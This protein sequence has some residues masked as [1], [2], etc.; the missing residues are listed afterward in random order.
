MPV[1]N[2]VI[3]EFQ[4]IADKMHA[5]H[6]AES[7]KSREERQ[8]DQKKHNDEVAA[9]LE[10]HKA[11]VK[12]DLET[13]RTEQARLIKERTSR[14]PTGLIGAP[15]GDMR[16]LGQR[17]A[18]ME[19]YKAWAANDHRTKAPLQLGLK[20]RIRQPIE[21]KVAGTIVETGFPMVP[22]RVGYFAP[23]TLPLVMRDLLTVVTLTSGNSIDYVVETWNYAANYQV[24]EGDPK[25]QGDVTYL[26]KT[27]SVR[28]IA[29]YVKASRQMMA[30]APYF[31]ATVDSQLLYGLAKKEDHEILLGDN[32]AGHL[33]GII[34][35]ATAL[36][37]DI[38][39][40]ILNSFDQVLAAVAY[41]ASI[42]YSPTAI[43]LNPIDWANMQIAK[44][45]Q[46]IYILGGPP[47]GMAARTLWGLPVVMTSE[48]ALGTFLVG[49][50]PPNATL[51]DRESPSVDIAYENEDDFIKNLVTIRAEERIA[52]AVFRPQAFVTSTLVPP[53]VP[54][55][56][57]APAPK[58]KR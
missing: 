19:Q 13:L 18:E 52:L 1:D 36:P 3:G 11:E 38:L 51:F 49:A 57:A 43:V 30:D 9:L 17:F 50:F 7:V 16:S 23:P 45:S 4:K 25:A 8:A 27:A 31:A 55:A 58:E 41:L 48:M 47:S 21:V 56:A 15:D 5:D 24:L 37:A 29:W 33:H 26:E 46:G 39:T 12:T 35:Q 32:S 53:V 34:P 10:K 54:F 40:D 22:T 2:E 6:Q 20:G 14:P 28:T 42:G 44:T